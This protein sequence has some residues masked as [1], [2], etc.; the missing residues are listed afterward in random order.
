MLTQLLLAEDD[1]DLG[2][3]L[4][5]FLELNSFEVTLATDGLAARQALNGQRFDIAVLDVMMPGEDGFSLVKKTREV[6]PDLPFIF[7]TARKQ[8]EDILAGLQLGADDYMTKPFNAQE[9]VLRIRNILRRTA[10]QPQET[11]DVIALGKFTFEP[12]LLRLSSK[13][14]EILLTEKETRLLYYLYS[15]RGRLIRRS[16]ILEQLWSTPDFFSGRSMD[17]FITRLRKHLATDPAIEIESIRGI[18]F[19][20]KCS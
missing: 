11:A 18:G 17:V 12:A 2:R 3:L 4:K 8:P 7:L 9:L 1:Q 10:S 20:F 13:S 14:G 5:Q 16:Q 15:H 6:F 19:R